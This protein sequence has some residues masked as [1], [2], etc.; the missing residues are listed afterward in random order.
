[1]LNWLSINARWNHS[2][3]SR[4]PKWCYFS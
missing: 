3:S 2:K 1:L 4:S